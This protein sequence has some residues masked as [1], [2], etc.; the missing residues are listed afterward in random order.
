MDMNARYGNHLPPGT[1]RVTA[2]LDSDLLRKACSVTGEGITETLTIGLEMAPPLGRRE[3]GAGAPRQASAR[4]GPGRRS[5]VSALV[6][7]TSSWVTYLGRGKG[8]LL[9]EAPRGGARAPPA[10]R[11]RGIALRPAG[12]RGQRRALE[13]L[14]LR[15]LSLCAADR[16]H[17]FRVGR[18]RG[19][20]RGE[21]TV[22]RPLHARCRAHVAQCTLDLGGAL[23]TEDRVFARVARH[24]PLR[25]A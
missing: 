13:D 24:V 5:A 6:V 9:E 3:E 1:R 17:W 8:D 15:S 4:P 20:P 14:P 19:S 21:G 2:N 18:L 12:A 16:D 23:L 10:G 22:A 25:L 11:R 7:D